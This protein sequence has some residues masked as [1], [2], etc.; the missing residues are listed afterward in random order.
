MS[1]EN[2]TSNPVTAVIHPTPKEGVYSREDF[3][4]DL[5]KVSKKSTP[6]SARPAAPRK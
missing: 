1:Q 5:S 4:R 6:S 3:T 2:L